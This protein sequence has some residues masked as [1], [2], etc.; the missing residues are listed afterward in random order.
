MQTHPTDNFPGNDVDLGVEDND[1]SERQVECNNGGV[2]L[3]DGGL[4]HMA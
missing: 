1:D 2:Q 3:V 4:G